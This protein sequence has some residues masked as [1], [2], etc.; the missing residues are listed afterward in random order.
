MASTDNIPVDIEFLFKNINVGKEAEKIKKEITDIGATTDK[1]TE[2]VEANFT[3]A[4]TKASAEAAET[5]TSFAEGAAGA[6]QF[7]KGNQQLTYSMQQVA[8]ELPSLAISPQLF[9]LAI[10]NNLPI[11]Q[12][13]IR[14]TRIENEDLKASGASTVPVW[15]QLVSSLFSWQTALVAGITIITVYGK[16]ITE[17]IGNLFSMR[18]ATKLTKDEQQALVSKMQE[19]IIILNTLVGKIKTTAAGTKARADAI[20]TL[21]EKYGKYLDNLLTEK[22]T[23]QEIEQAQQRATN[24]LIAFE[25]N[26]ELGTKLGKLYGEV[27]KK[28]STEMT[29][30]VNL[31]GEQKGVLNIPDFVIAV[32]DAIDKQIKEGKGKIERG[33]LEYSQIALDVYR[34]FFADIKG[35][36]ASRYSYDNFLESFLDFA[37]FKADK[38]GFILT[39]QGMQNAF[40]SMTK[41]FEDGKGR[42]VEVINNEIADLQKLQKERSKNATEYAKYQKQIDNLI[43][44]RAAITAEKDVK[45]T[46]EALKKAQE[47]YK[48][49]LKA[50]EQEYLNYNAALRQYGKEWADANYQL[51]L[52]D[53]DSFKEYLE[54]QV[55]QFRESRD[56]MIAIAQTAQSSGINLFEPDWLK[57]KIKTL[58]TSKV[59]VN[60]NPLLDTT[61]LAGLEGWYKKIQERL[62]KLSK[63][64]NS[65]ELKNY[66]DGLIETGYILGDVAADIKDVNESLGESVSNIGKMAINMGNIIAG[67]ASDNPFQVLSGGFGLLTNFITGINDVLKNTQEVTEQLKEVS[68]LIDSIEKAKDQ[69]TS[70]DL[71]KY[72]NLQV[73]LLQKQIREK[74]K[75]YDPYGLT[76]LLDTYDISLVLNYFSSISE[77]QGGLSEGFKE[78]LDGM[79]DLLGQYESILREQQETLLGFTYQDF[80]SKLADGIINGFDLAYNGMGDFAQ[81]FGEL[82][83]MYGRKS[84]ETFINDK[85]LAKIFELAYS[86]AS[87]ND[88]LTQA[89]SKLLEDKTRE[90]ILAAQSFYESVSWAFNQEANKGYTPLTGSTISATEE[91]VSLLYGAVTALRIDVKGILSNMAAHDDDIVIHLA[92]MKRIADNTDNNKELPLMKQQLEKMNKILEERL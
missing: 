58:G 10:S 23:L 6:T 47:K 19:E 69:L 27:A 46:D 89:D 34:K 37:K 91:S 67:V 64:Y 12:D 71:I 28:F 9:F 15:R 75:T 2:Q 72:T 83:E 92:Y 20:D 16:Q 1:V 60:Q 66:G 81:T 77:M 38:S 22:S 24:A 42:T 73:D 52:K 33:T 14:K 76:G 8:R 49:T 40:D 29:D 17:A 26:K 18:Q 57:P 90:A 63:Q 36:N 43:N 65:D 7:A 85:Y 82:M 25:A 3:E 51:L 44:E 59:S 48:E 74:M 54:N 30:F 53:G 45:S 70:K 88:G 31:I 87:D 68:Y 4:F 61:K 78:Q 41:T 84:L 79:I 21:N 55:T 13:Q 39:L 86:L 35:I 50:K 32:N 56:K 62:D 5:N 80:A 11:L